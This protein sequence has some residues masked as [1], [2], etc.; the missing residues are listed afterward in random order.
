MKKRYLYLAVAV[1]FAGCT[2]VLEEKVSVVSNGLTSP[3]TITAVFESSPQ[4]LTLEALPGKARLQGRR[5]TG[6]R[7]MRLPSTAFPARK[8]SDM[9]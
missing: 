3:E 6:T 8:A 9:S 1:V 2:D 7:V 4:R 5:L